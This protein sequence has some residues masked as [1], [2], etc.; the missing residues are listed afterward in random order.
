VI[1]EVVLRM[2]G[3]VHHVD[4]ASAPEGDPV[5]F[6]EHEDPVLVDRLHRAPGVEELLLTED[7]ACRIPQSVRRH[8]VA[9]TLRVNADPGVGVPAGEV[10][11]PSGVIDVD[12]GDR[13]HGEVVDAHVVEGTKQVLDAS[14][15]ATF[16]EDSL[17]G[18]EQVAGE[19]VGLVLHHRVDE[20]EVIAQI[21]DAHVG[22]GR[23]GYRHEI[24][25]SAPIRSTCPPRK[26]SNGWI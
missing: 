2:A 6:V 5:A 21:G 10:A 15:R 4:E 22:H 16:D 24:R 7:P 23:R 25:H 13:H 8:E 11:G 20:I 14:A 9:G 1:D 26:G 17:G 3:C 12:V 19:P 18:V